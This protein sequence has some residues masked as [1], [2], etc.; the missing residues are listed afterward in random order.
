MR[1]KEIEQIELIVKLLNI[2]R[3]AKGMELLDM[4]QEI[5]NLEMKKV[6]REQD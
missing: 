2:L 1:K 6:L 4:K 3:K 5:R